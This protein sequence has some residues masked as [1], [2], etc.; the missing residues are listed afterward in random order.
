[1][2]L[3]GIAGTAG[4]SVVHG[5]RK[6]EKL[7]PALLPCSEQFR[8]QHSRAMDTSGARL[9]NRAA[10]QQASIRAVA[11]APSCALTPLALLSKAMRRIKFTDRF[12]ILM[13]GYLVAGRAVKRSADL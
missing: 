13:Q 7:I 2:R 9:A 11:P 6:L 1:M 4:H 10:L 8:L 5:L 3:E 12:R